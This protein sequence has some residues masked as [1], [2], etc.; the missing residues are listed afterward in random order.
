MAGRNKRMKNAPRK[1]SD[2]FG[3]PSIPAKPRTIHQTWLKDVG[4]DEAPWYLERMGLTELEDF[5]DVAGSNLDYVKIVTTQVLNHPK[6][7]LK[8][9]IKL[10]H[11]FGIEPYLDHGYF[12]LAFKHGVVEDAIIAGADLGF[13]VIEFMNTFGDVSEK[14]WKNWRQL[15]LDHG[16][17]II[18]EHHPESGWRNNTKNTPVSAEDIIKG[19]SPFLEHG[20]FKIMLD[21][22]E[23][24]IQGRASQERFS[25]LIDQ[26]GLE[27][28]VFEVTSPKESPLQWF[29]DVTAY[30]ELF[31]ADCNV[32]NIM[33]SQAMYIE[34]LRR[35]ERPGPLIEN[36]Y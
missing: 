22:E 10:Y 34:P 7:W 14:Q 20:A 35:G 25:K 6:E 1:M 15:A 21:H 3:H 4:F 11:S 30:F 32:S 9:K 31:G 8:R 19:A 12:K 24:E 17:K 5:L 13:R 36:K 23:F 16:M 2:L 28:I 29:D 33:P 18:Y 27:N 26:V